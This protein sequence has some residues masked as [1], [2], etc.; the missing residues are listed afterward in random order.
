M[1]TLFIVLASLA[2]L[3]FVGWAVSQS[4]SGCLGGL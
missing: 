1:K 4:V 2:I 3:F